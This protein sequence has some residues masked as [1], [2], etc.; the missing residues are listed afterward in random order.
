MTEL[1]PVNFKKEMKNSN[2]LK[3][4]QEQIRSIE[5][6]KTWELMHKLSNNPIDVKWVYKL[7]LRLNGE[8]SKYKARLL[9]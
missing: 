9:A 2:W 3:A 8:L 6:N 4:M 7:K 5:K 1:E